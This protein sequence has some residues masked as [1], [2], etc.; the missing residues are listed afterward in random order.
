[1]CLTAFG[2]TYRFT[3]GLQAADNVIDNAGVNECHRVVFFES[4]VAELELVVFIAI[5]SKFISKV[6]IPGKGS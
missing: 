4:R 3:T 2:P 6:P 5:R 1:M